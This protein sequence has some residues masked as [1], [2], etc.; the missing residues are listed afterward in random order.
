FFPRHHGRYFIGEKPLFH[1]H[2]RDGRVLK[3]VQSARRSYPKIPFSIFQD[4]LH[5]V[6]AE[7]IERSKH[8]PTPVRV[9]AESFPICPNPQVSRRIFKDGRNLAVFQNLPKRLELL[10]SL[11]QTIKP[12]L[13]PHPKIAFAV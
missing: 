4:R 7:P 12:F 3:P 2:R 13:R 8:L 6:I 9:A 5:V 1:C 11:R 10:S